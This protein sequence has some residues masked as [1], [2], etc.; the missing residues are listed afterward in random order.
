MTTV[1][2]TYDRAVT[3]SKNESRVRSRSTLLALN[4]AGA[5]AAAIFAAV[6]LIQ[7]SYVEAGASSTPTSLTGFWAASS[8]V[9]TWAVTIPLLGGLALTGRPAPQLLTVAGLVQLGDSALGIRQRN[10]AM[11]LAPG[12]MGLLHL[13]SARVLSR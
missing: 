13:A 4:G 10:L 7:P 11:T 8:A 1:P 12:A 3:Y 6:G 2:S 9:R 5:T